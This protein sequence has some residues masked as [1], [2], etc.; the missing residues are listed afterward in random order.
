MVNPLFAAG[1]TAALMSE[2]SRKVLRRGIVYG[3]AGAIT[4]FDAVVGAAEGV[5]HSAE[6]VASSAGGFAGG[7]VGDRQESH[8]GAAGRDRGRP[9]PSH[10]PRPSRT[11]QPSRASSGQRA[12]ASASRRRPAGASKTGTAK[13][14]PAPRE[15]L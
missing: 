9:Q 5:V 8:D 4:V 12:S 6:Y 11:T 2:R 10:P 13:T 7:L 3:L 15:P 1:A 14:S